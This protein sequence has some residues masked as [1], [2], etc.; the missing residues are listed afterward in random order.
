MLRNSSRPW[1]CHVADEHFQL[2][3]ASCI[4]PYQEN[5]LCFGALKPVAGF[6][7]P[8]LTFL[9]G[10]FHHKVVAPTLRKS[11]LRKA[12]T[13]RL[14]P[15]FR[16]TCCGFYSGTWGFTVCTREAPLLKLWAAR[17]QPQVLPPQ[18]PRLSLSLHGK[19]GVGPRSGL[20][21]G[22]RD[23]RGRSRGPSRPLELSPPVLRLL[24]SLSITLQSRL[25]PSRNLSFAAATGLTR[26]IICCLP[27]CAGRKLNWE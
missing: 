20:C 10:I 3:A 26:D 12:F 18:L 9:D 25:V 4:S 27:M 14:S 16:I 6:S 17:C 19:Q 5:H 24:P 15:T 8:A 2:K 7:S 11:T 1:H 23:R 22:F 21:L 13:H